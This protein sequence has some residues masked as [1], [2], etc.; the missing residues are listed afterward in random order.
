MAERITVLIPARNEESSIEACLRSLLAQ[1]AELEVWVADD[2]S[3]DRTAEIVRQVAREDDRAHL[4]SVPPLP[5]GWTGKNHALD[6]AMRAIRNSDGW[7]L[8][9][10]A[11]TVHEPG[12][13]R[14]MVERAEREGLDLFSLSPRQETRAWYEKAVI[15]R[16]YRALERLYAFEAINDPASAAAAA[17][18]QY[19]L[20]R[21][22]AYARIGGHAAFPGEI[23]EDVALARAAKRAGLRIRFESGNGLVRARMYR[24]W[25]ALWQGWSKN[26]YLLYGRRPLRLLAA[27]GWIWLA[28]IIPVLFVLHFPAAVLAWLAA[29]HAWYAARLHRAGESARLSV[30]YWPGSVIFSALL[31][32]SLIKYVF[33]Q[34]VVW[35]D[36]SYTQP[37]AAG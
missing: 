23:L 28:D 2:A 27:A 3:T 32:G 9:T 29:R 20:I 16:V 8:F 17:N 15:P 35:K 22:A 21:R 26:L 13:L 36:R 1:D 25:S 4:L 34:S 37:R 11:D 33:K 24:S 6:F 5:P 31:I 10:D 30:Y 18:G 12:G 14:R 19:L 7:L